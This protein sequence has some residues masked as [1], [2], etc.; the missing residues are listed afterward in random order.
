MRCIFLG[1]GGVEEPARLFERESVFH[2][3][4]CIV[5]T[6]RAFD[7]KRVILQF[8]CGLEEMEL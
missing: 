4:A 3:A 1:P 5:F 8:Q 6:C 7:N 2:S